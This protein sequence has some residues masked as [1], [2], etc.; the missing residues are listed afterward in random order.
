ERAKLRKQL[1][2]LL[3]AGGGYL[4]LRVVVVD[5]YPTTYRRNPL[6]YAAATVATGETLF[7][8]HCT[9]CHGLD[10][11]GDGPAAAGLNPRPADLTAP[12]VDDHTDGD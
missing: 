5:A 8:T 7:R 10:G 3:M 9:V 1:A 4:V 2:D 6:P 11:R 12:H